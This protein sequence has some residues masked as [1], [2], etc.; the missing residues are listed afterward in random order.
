MDDPRLLARYP[1]LKAASAFV[2]ESGPTLEE[3]LTHPAYARARSRG[4]TRAHAA[5]RDGD[6]P[7]EEA[8]DASDGILHLLAYAVARMLASLA[9]DRYV[10]RRHALAESLRVRAFV[11]R[12]RPRVV[13]E[14]ADDLGVAVD[15]DE[16]TSTYSLHFGD[17]LRHAVVLKDTTWKLVNQEFAAPGRV[18]LTQ[19]RLA[20]LLQEAY[21]ARAESELPLPVDET[22]G[23]AL[24]PD[25]AVVM[26][27]ARVKKEQI[28]TEDFGELDLESLPPCMKHILGMIQTGVN[29]P[30][31]ARFA[32]T[33]FLHTVGEDSEAIIRLFSKAPDFKEEMT[34]YQVEHITGKSS[35]TEYTPPGCQAM[36]TYGIC[37]N[38]D[39]WC[40]S[41]APDGH[42]YVTH[43]LSYYRWA[44]KRKARGAAPSASP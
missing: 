38:P 1:F 17:Y 34:R 5:V 41:K 44:L 25:L 10:I 20:R 40:E 23:K 35:S 37:Y 15:F 14:V 21:R 27:E 13:E 4:R 29:A 36:K 12:E 6:L 7:A 26:E 24:A 33:S 9:D 11:E 42:L 31:S 16:P 43:P 28:K 39:R 32:I 30:H 2:A 22:V 3:L 18:R 19:P 8:T